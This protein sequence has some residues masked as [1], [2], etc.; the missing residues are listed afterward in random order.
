MILTHCQGYHIE[1]NGSFDP[2]AKGAGLN[3]ELSQ[4]LLTNSL[5]KFLFSRTPTAAWPMTSI[6]GPNKQR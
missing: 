6:K 4:G 5:G 2:N 3:E 1:D